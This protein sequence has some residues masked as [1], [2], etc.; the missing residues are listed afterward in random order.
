M[1]HDA[2]P[3][4]FYENGGPPIL[5]SGD[6]AFHGN[7]QQ[8]FS[9]GDAHGATYDLRHAWLSDPDTQSQL[10]TL[11]SADFGWRT[12]KKHTTTPLS[13]SLYDYEMGYSVS[14]GYAFMNTGGTIV[15][16]GHPAPIG[17]GDPG[18][19]PPAGFVFLFAIPHITR[20][21]FTLRSRDAAGQI[22]TLWLG[23][24]RGI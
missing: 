14:G 3:S 7:I 17:I 23:D 9:D 16:L 4:T 21:Q 22:S 18:V 5:Y 6:Q 11:D 13:S 10:I 2:V 15:P 12:M 19:N 1:P 8:V 20:N 24:Q